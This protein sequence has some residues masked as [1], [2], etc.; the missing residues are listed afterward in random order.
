MSASARLGGGVLVCLLAI[1]SGYAT[2]ASAASKLPCELVPAPAIAG[3]LR[4]TQIVEHEIAPVPFEPGGRLSECRIVAWNGSRSEAKIPNGARADLTIETAEE[5]A[6]SPLAAEW[7]KSGASNAQELRE[8]AFKEMVAG[9]EGYVMIRHVGAELWDRERAVGPGFDLSGFDEIEE[10][11]KEAHGKRE[12]YVTWRAAE[13]PGRS[14]SLNIVI[15]E[16]EHAFPELNK[17]AESALPAF[18]LA[19][20]EFGT[21]GPPAPEAHEHRGQRYKQCPGAVVV[22]ANGQH[23]EHFEVLGTSC[24]TAAAVMREVARS[25]HPPAGWQLSEPAMNTEAGRNGR[26]RFVCYDT[27]AEN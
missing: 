23:L 26:A 5:N 20:G 13:R 25:G 21:P 4:L 17:I 15:D 1:G 9:A 11:G 16:R 6:E 27:T 19:P 10:H 12:I 22:D 3:A 14:I 7:A 2:T 24:A 18:A 8:A